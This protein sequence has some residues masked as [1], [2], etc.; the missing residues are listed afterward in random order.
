MVIP[1][2]MLALL[3]LIG[4]RALMGVVAHDDTAIPMTVAPEP[5]PGRGVWGDDARALMMPAASGHIDLA[6][7]DDSADANA[8]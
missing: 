7:V 6:Q 8:S 1:A 4:I 2:V 5:E 3:A